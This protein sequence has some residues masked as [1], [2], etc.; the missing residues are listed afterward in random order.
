MMSECAKYKDELLEAALTGS[1]EGLLEVHLR[2]CAA[3]TEGL[4]TLRARREKMDALL[5]LVARGAEPS[6][7]FRARVLTAAETTGNRRKTRA[8]RVW[9]LAGA[10]AAV[11]TALMTGWILEQRKGRL[12]AESEIAAAQKL[13]EW[14]APSDVLLETPGNEILRT[15][16]KVGE[17][18]LKVTAKKDREE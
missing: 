12:G 5:P 7:G 4:A 3:C 15:T 2:D 6:T 10:T 11:A 17:A 9:V 18:Y 1:A 16:P 8:W 13:A 14:R